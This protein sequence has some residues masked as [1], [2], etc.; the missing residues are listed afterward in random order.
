MCILLAV[1]LMRIEPPRIG[2]DITC[3]EKIF[4][5]YDL[6]L[7]VGASVV[8]PDAVVG[9]G[10]AVMIVANVPEVVTTDIMQCHFEF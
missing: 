1:T 5:L 3:Q 7:P 4:S 6:L 2:A 8:T 9:P 10:A